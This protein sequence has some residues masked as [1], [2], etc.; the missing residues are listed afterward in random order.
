MSEI[1]PRCCLALGV[2]CTHYVLTNSQQLVHSM[3]LI[4][5]TKQELPF[6][7]WRVFG[8]LVSLPPVSS[9]RSY[10]ETCSSL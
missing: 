8:H 6:P 4:T 2:Y 3:I 9:I 10:H 5:G 7:T 1:Y